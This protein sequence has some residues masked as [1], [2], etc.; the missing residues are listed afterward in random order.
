MEKQTVKELMLE[1]NK[2]VADGYGDALIAVPYEWGNGCVNIVKGYELV[3]DCSKCN[4]NSPCT[5]SCIK[6]NKKADCVMLNS[7]DMD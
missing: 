6:N 4:D 3:Y 5:K 2:L 1:L 7:D